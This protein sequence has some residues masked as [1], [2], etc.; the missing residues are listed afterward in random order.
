MAYAFFSIFAPEKIQS[1]FLV[2]CFVMEF[3]ISCVRLKAQNH[4]EFLYGRPNKRMPLTVTLS[5]KRA[6]ISYHDSLA[7]FVAESR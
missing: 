4:Y 6:N 7:G 1:E 5:M 3:P 2:N